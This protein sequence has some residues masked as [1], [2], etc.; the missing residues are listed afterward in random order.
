MKGSL[1]ERIGKMV[2]G[3]KALFGQSAPEAERSRAARHYLF[4]TATVRLPSGGM[5]E[6]IVKNLS[7]SGASIEFRGPKLPDK[8]LIIEPSLKLH[9]W[10]KVVWQSA[11]GAGLKFIADETVRGSASTNAPAPA[12]A[13]SVRSRL[14]YQTPKQFG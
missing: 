9:R 10:A 7:A 1:G 2:R 3:S 8:V 14:R 13:P 6:V 11:G 4:K 5:V 12:G